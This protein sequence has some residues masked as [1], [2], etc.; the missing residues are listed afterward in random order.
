MRSFRFRESGKASLVASPLGSG[1]LVEVPR[2]VQTTRAGGHMRYCDANI[3]TA[4]AQKEKVPPFWRDLS[5][6]N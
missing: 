5:F 3:A 2:Q 1:N 4:D 6:K